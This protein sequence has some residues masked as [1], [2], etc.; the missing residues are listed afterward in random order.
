MLVAD[1][2]MSTG[3]VLL[4]V[5][6]GFLLTKLVPASWLN[7]GIFEPSSEVG[8]TYFFL[9]PTLF[10][11]GMAIQIDHASSLIALKFLAF[12]YLVIPANLFLVERMIY[13]LW[14]RNSQQSYPFKTVVISYLVIFSVALLATL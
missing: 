4:G 10:F 9:F 12:Q 1:V 7:S 11:A 5:F 8:K 13:L 6:V 2:L 3:L 14:I